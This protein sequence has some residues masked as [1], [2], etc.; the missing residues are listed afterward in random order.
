MDADQPGYSLGAITMAELHEYRCELEHSL[1]VLSPEAPVRSLLVVGRPFRI[2]SSVFPFIRSYVL[3]L[4]WLRLLRTCSPW[5]LV[6][7]SR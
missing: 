3:I 2:A 7:A 4:P 1:T 6:E 5:L